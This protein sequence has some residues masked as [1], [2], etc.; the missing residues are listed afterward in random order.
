VV[1]PLSVTLIV[2]SLSLGTGGNNGGYIVDLIGGGFP[3]IPSQ[4]SIT[5]CSNAATILTTSNIHV[6]FYVPSCDSLGNSP[7]VVTVN[8]ISDNTLSFTYLNGSSYAPTIISL[9]P[10]S[11]NPGIKG[12][13][14]ITGTNFGTNT[15]A[16]KVFLSNATGKIYQLPI[17]TLN[18]SSILA[19]LPGGES[20]IFTLQVSLPSGNGDSIPATNNANIFTYIFSVSSISP[21]TGSYNGGTLLTITG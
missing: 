19:G 16:I 9:S 20:G 14:G 15:S 7:V 17:L 5:I 12:T 8:G 11:A 13:I 2:S 18:D 10:A 3:L 21:N 1:T 6:T 4:I